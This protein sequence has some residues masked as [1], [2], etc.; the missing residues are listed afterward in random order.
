M[1]RG[2]T[3]G[4]ASRRSCGT[5]GGGGSG[6]S[7][8]CC[9]R[10]TGAGGLPRRQYSSLIRPP[11]PNSSNLLLPWPPVNGG[12]QRG[13]SRFLPGQYSGLPRE[14]QE[15]GLE[16][17]LGILG[18]MQ[19]PL[20]NAQ[21]HRAMPGQ[22]LGEGRFIPFAGKSLKEFAVG[23]RPGPSPGNEPAKVVQENSGVTRGHDR[24]S[25]RNRSLFSI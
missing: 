11:N 19:D 5:S 1:W 24:E 23:Q 14:H 25:R 8:S 9:W 21:D 2:P 4:S 22:Q 17:V 20:A 16:S 15:C 7:A 3:G 18:L 6:W 13:V 12:D 10:W